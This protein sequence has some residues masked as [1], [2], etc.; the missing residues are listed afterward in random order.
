M[1][2]GKG[3][4]HLSPKAF[5]LLRLLVESRPRAISKEEFFGRLWPDTFVTEANLAGLVAEIRREIGDDARE[6]RFLRTVHGFG[7]AFSDGAART[8]DEDGVFRLIWGAREVPLVEGENVLGRDPGAAVSIDDATVSRHHA[9]IVIGG[10]SAVLE[11]LGSKN[12]TWLRGRRIAS[13]EP[14]ADG[15][16]LRIGSAPFIFRRYAAGGSTETERDS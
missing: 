15:D 13:S 3:A 16:E 2:R 11:D 6:P 5:E 14:L 7:Y 10:R 12:G 8:A 9:R 4:V 1:R